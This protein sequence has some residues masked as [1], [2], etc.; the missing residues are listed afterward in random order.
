MQP[1]KLSLS[2][3]SKLNFAG[4]KHLKQTVG[5]GFNLSKYVIYV[6]GFLGSWDVK[7]LLFNLLYL[8][9][10]KE[11]P[12]FLLFPKDKYGQRLK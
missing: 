10:I 5:R 11:T 4:F 2:Y 1:L 8:S 9:E 3:L 7:Y 6:V 12:T